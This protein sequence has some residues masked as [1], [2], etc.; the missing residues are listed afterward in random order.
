MP[1]YGQMD[2]A[3]TGGDNAGIKLP[4]DGN[5]TVNFKEVDIKTVLSYLSEISGVDI[6]PTPGV[7]GLVT[8]RLRDKPWLVALDIVTRNHGYTYSQEQDII[9]VMP[10][11]MLQTESA[12]TEVIP[13]NY[14]IKNSK[15]EN[16]RQKGR[17]SSGAVGGCGISCPG[18]TNHV[19]LLHNKFL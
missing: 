7:E 15:D 12:I 5:I 18:K 10:R 13:L 11:S 3:P 19:V 1:V 8:M 2:I 14:I 17:N 9:R 16:Q 4:G 6:V